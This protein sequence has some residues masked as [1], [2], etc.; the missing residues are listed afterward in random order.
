MPARM[1]APHAHMP[2][3]MQKGMHA[4]SN[5]CTRQCSACISPSL[6]HVPWYTKTILHAA[7]PRSASSGQLPAR[8][9]DV[10]CPA[11]PTARDC[12]A[13]PAGEERSPAA[14]PHR[15][16]RRAG[17]PSRVYPVSQPIQSMRLDARNAAPLRAGR[18]HR[19][20]RL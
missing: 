5:P 4:A 9:R 13:P 10:L 12:D 15:P 8:G 11:P 2:A 19:W 7:A 18:E 17:P 16:P 3:R 6:L 20:A 14:L 1:P